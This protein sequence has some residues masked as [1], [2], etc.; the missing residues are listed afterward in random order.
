MAP[1]GRSWPHYIVGV[2]LNGVFFGI[3]GPFIGTVVFVG[4]IGFLTLPFAIYVGY[5]IGAFP[6][7]VAGCI[8]A[9]GSSVIVEQARLR[10]L[11]SLVGAMTAISLTGFGMQPPPAFGGTSSGYPNVLL[12]M[13]LGIAGAAS[14]FLCTV[15]AQ[16]WGLLLKRPAP[17][18]TRQSSSN[19]PN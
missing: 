7:F 6:A 5:W 3:F 18:S 8:T 19:S 11:S 17:S 16:K 2:G 9:I 15:L 10:I 13:P 1:H 14:A 12:F 4:G